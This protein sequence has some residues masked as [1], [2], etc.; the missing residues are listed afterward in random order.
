MDQLP[1]ET[2]QIMGRAQAAVIAAVEQP[3]RPSSRERSTTATATGTISHRRPTRDFLGLDCSSPRP[4][5]HLDT[6]GRVTEAKV[7]A[8][9]IGQV[10]KVGE[11]RQGW[12]G[13]NLC[14]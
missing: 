8:I 4:A 12:L 1:F 14:Y 2:V 5:H 10:P 11:E 9:V 3:T 6:P 7:D 13:I